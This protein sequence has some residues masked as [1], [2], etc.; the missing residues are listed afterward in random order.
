MAVSV[1]LAG[2]ALS[3]AS[4]GGSGASSRAHDGR[5]LFIA[6]C[7]SCHTLRA[8]SATGTDGGN[9][10]RLF[11]N[12]KRSTIG[13]IVARA[14]RNGVAGMPAGI[15]ADGDANA[16]AA[17][18]ASV[19]GKPAPA[20]TAAQIKALLLK[21]LAPV[22]KLAT[23]A[24]L[25]KHGGYSFSFNAPSAG[26]LVVSWY[27]VPNGAHL[28]SGKPKPVL[29]ATGKAS[30]TKPGTVKIML[31]LT[32]KGHQ[33]LEHA[34]QLKL[35]AEATFIPTNKTAVIAFKTFTLER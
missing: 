5:E 24:A 14:I 1:V 22:G 16:V 35:T 18:V 28:A 13:G 6:N 30:F 7:A 20:P 10:D 34:N 32:R 15:L 11:R 9:L 21:Q 23:I 2:G 8:A 33:L 25:L 29:I 19:T 17:Y 26:R 27:Q 4:A 12:T 3:T 31:N